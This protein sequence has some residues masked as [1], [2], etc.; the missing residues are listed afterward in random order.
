MCNGSPDT[1]STI[2][3]KLLAVDGSGSGLDAD[4]VDGFNI[5]ALFCT[6]VQTAGTGASG[7]NDCFLGQVELTAANYPP[8]G[9]AFAAGQTL[10]ISMNSALFSVIGV[11]YGG[12][13]STTFMLPDLR[14]QAPG[15]TTY[16]ICVEGLYP[17]RS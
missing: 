2:L 14:K 9:T 17:S 13:G 15:G 11:D 6:G 7:S 10:P 3:G 12:N 16:T 1:G 4:T 8:P 5:G